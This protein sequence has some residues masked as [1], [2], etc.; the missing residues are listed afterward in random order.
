VLATIAAAVLSG[1]LPAWMSSRA[2]ASAALRDGGRGT[3]LPGPERPV[4]AQSASS[5]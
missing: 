4:R 3:Q 1:L 2:N 5:A